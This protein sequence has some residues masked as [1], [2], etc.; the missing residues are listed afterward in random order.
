MSTAAPATHQ[1]RLGALA[2][3]LGGLALRY[4]AERDSR[5]V[6]TY[7][8]AYMTERLA[9]AMP[10]AGLDDPDWVVALAEEFGGLYVAA[11]TGWD[12]DRESVPAGWQ[13]VFGTI[14]PRRT[15]P[16]EDLVFAM[17]AHIVRDLPHALT[18]VG[19]E[20][21]A[22]R[23]HVR[24]FH[25]V[26]RI[27]GETINEMQSRIGKRYAPYLRWLDRVGRAHDELLSNYGILVSRGMAWYNAT[28]LLDPASTQDAGRSV[29]KS[30]GDFVKQIMKQPLLRL[31]RLL[32][33]SLRRWPAAQRA[34]T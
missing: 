30:P 20:D 33:H 31:L 1:A 22:G 6:F 4:E 13:A 16:L 11:V 5:C 25:T 14:C 27:M 2:E 26:N 23:S 32:V 12:E 10:A 29:E 17:A 15:S 8:Y 19:L 9:E 34:S 21:A 18:A 28:R 24:D 7:A 3:Q